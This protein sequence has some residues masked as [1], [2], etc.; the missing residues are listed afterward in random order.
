MQPNSRIAEAIA[1]FRRGDLDRAR[2]LAKAQ[3][4]DENGPP[5]VHHLLGLIECRQGRVESGV[6]HLRAAVDA[7]PANAAFRVMLARA[8]NDSGRPAAA[9]DAAPA[10]KGTSAADMALWHVRAEAA[11]ALGDHAAAAEAWKVLAVAR[12]DDWR[13]PA[14]YGEALAGLGRWAEAANALRRASQLNPREIT[15]QQNLA[16]ALIKA[17]FYDEAVDR[18]RGMLESGEDDARTRLTLSRLLAVMG[19]DEESMAE[20]D[21]A[22]QA[23][24]RGNSAEGGLI[25]IALPDGPDASPPA[26]DAE[27]AALRELCSLLERTNRLDELKTLLDDAATLSIPREKLGYPAAAIALRDGAAADAR[28]LLEL[29]SPDADPVRWHRLMA[30]ILDSLGD[31][32]G[33]FDAAVAMNRAVP[34]FDGWVH[35][36]SAYCRR[37]RGLADT[38]TEDWAARIKPLAP[39]PRRSPAFLVGFPRSGTTLL[40]TFLMGHPGTQVL[41]ERHMLGAAETVLG[42]VARLPDRT[43]DELEQGRRAY[44]AELDKH[45]DRDFT[46]LVVDKLPLNMLGLPVIHSLFPDAKIIFAQRHPCDCVLSG[47]MQSFTLN[48]AMACFLT[49]EGSAELYDAAMRM[50]TASRDALP[51]QVHTLAYEELVSDPEAALTPLIG[52]LGLEWRPELLDHRATAKARGAIITPSYDQVVQPLSKAPSGRWRRYEEQLAPVL[53]VLLPWAARLGYAD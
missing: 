53:P 40:D 33:A 46:G 31:T 45:V 22:A 14:N 36:G 47:F 52:F 11:Q 12:P 17:G 4:D 38:V 34:D 9:L 41:E 39:S 7:Q 37:I 10:S 16:S 28:R 23:A 1:A 15:I 30:K 13:F 25:R 51:V 26:S 24:V 50:F 27:V 3:I 6:D 32:A 42:N 29:E 43:T 48:D 44:F 49:I 18:L 21:K 8:L 35:K 20:L 5:D 2:A 19:R